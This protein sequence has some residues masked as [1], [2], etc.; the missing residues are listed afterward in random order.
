[1]A[2]VLVKIERLIDAAG[3]EQ[4]VERPPSGQLFAAGSGLPG[5]RFG[6]LRKGAVRP[7][8]SP[9]PTAGTRSPRTRF[10][11]SHQRVG[12]SLGNVPR[13]SGSKEV[14]SGRATSSGAAAGAACPPLRGP[15]SGSPSHATNWIG[16]AAEFGA[17]CGGPRLTGSGRSGPIDSQPAVTNRRPSVPNRIRL[18]W[19]LRQ[20]I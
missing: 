9:P 18:P 19:Q 17:I 5:S 3:L 10:G 14:G 11:P 2:I 4:R 16:S 8:R 13:G 6:D 15:P 7:T 12:N 1:M 20:L